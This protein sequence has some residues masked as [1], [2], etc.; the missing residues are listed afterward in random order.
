MN[1]SHVTTSVVVAA[2]LLTTAT[3]CTG[4]QKALGLKQDL[5]KEQ[6]AAIALRLDD[7]AVCPGDATKLIVDVQLVDGR[8]LVSDGAGRG[9][10]T[11]DSFRVRGKGVKVKDDG[12]LE[13][14]EDPRTLLT[15]P[16]SVAVGLTHHKGIAGHL[17]VPIRFDC[18]YVVDLSGEDGEDG[19]DGDHGADAAEGTS[20]ESGTGGTS[21]TAGTDAKDAVV[22]VALFRTTDGLEL[23]QVQVTETGSSDEQHFLIDKRGSVLVKARGGQGGEGGD[24]GDGGEPTGQGGY[25][26]SGG[27]GG[28]GG[29]ITAVIDED[30]RPYADR[31]R[32]EVQG[33]RGGRMGT[34]G[35]NARKVPLSFASVVTSVAN[36]LSASNGRNGADGRVNVRHEPLESI[37]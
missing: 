3:G 26:G 16:P 4:I 2:A 12:V 20:A 8:T 33:G 22:K 27:D 29:T 34:Q 17:D 36:S 24:G 1:R 31:V 35:T 9:K 21:G 5:E 32:F 6:V 37:W 13:L 10:V 30:A 28:R 14:D 15:S 25:A 7:G 18:Q 19:D 11:W 23:L